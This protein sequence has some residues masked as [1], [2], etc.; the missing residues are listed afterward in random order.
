APRMAEGKPDLSGVWWNGGEVGSRWWRGGG[1]RG[2]RG[3]PAPPSFTSLYNAAAL[4]KAKTLNDSYDP[5][6]RCIPTAFGTLNLSLYSVGAVGQIISTPKFVVML[7]ETYHG[8]QL[9]PT[10]RPRR[11]E[12]IP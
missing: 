6:L 11:H 3:A 9:S 5:T 1:A 7:Q 10:E 4:E 2:A 12:R 8:Y